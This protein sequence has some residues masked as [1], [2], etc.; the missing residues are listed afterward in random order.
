MPENTHKIKKTETNLIWQQIPKLKNI[1]NILIKFEIHICQLITKSLLKQESLSQIRHCLTRLNQIWHNL[2]H[3]ITLKCLNDLQNQNLSILWLKWAQTMKMKQYQIFR[4]LS[5]S[6]FLSLW[7][8][9]IQKIGT[10][11]NH[12]SS[13]G[14]I[15][16]WH[17]IFF[18]KKY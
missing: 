13:M 11:Q 7:R 12:Y 3:Q 6:K 18:V 14:H 9:W 16:V 1:K 10:K 17:H 5:N 15:Q 2:F 4:P 8:K